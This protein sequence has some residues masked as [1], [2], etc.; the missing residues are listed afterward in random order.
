MTDQPS[1]D[2]R[3]FM[4]ASTLATIGGAAA[5]VAL[6]SDHAAAQ[7][8][9]GKFPGGT[10]FT[11]DVVHEKPVVS[12]L[13]VADLEPG[14]LH[15]LYFRGVEGPSGQAWLV[16][17]AVLRGARP[18]KRVTL[19]SGVHGDEMS[20]IRAVQTIMNKLDPAVMSGTVMAVFDVSRPAIESMG[21]RWPNSGRG[22]D[23]V[24][25]NRVWPGDENGPGA[26]ARHAGLLF[27]RLIRPNSDY[28]LDFHTSTTG[29]DA[30]AFHLADMTVPEVKAM[31]ELFPIDQ[32]FD[33]TGYPGLLTDALAKVGIPALTPEIGNARSL[34]LSMIPLFVEGTMNVLK[35][36]GIIEGPIGRTGRDT[37]IFVGNTLAPVLATAGGLVE[38][39]VKLGDAVSAGQKIAIQCN[40]FGEVVAEYRSPVDGEIG[41][42]RSDATSE[43]GNVIAFILF[44]RPTLEKAE[45]YPE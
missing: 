8:P 28:V 33:S 20:S 34:D 43:P 12:A 39:L 2:R 35:L 3:D 19:V 44:N 6:S 21:R 5:T 36:H 42:F 38:H 37:G 23:L 31:A 41:G 32:I 9:M 24:D 30:V 15:R 10:V 11:G 17:V 40:M 16:S 13:G 29:I 18:G 27:N 25:L 1:L 4:L 22:A 7:A 45:P 26:P 14:K